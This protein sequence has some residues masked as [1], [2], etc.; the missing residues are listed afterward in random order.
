M[1]HK[2]GEHAITAGADPGFTKG[3]A[4]IHCSEHDNCV[5]ST[6]SG[7]QS[8]PKLGGSGGMPPRKFWKIRPS[9]IEFEGTFNGLLLLLLIPRQ[10]AH[11]KK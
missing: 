2:T 7:M 8:M 5:R 3:G 6:Q 4:Q 10:H 1:H 11:C 9:E